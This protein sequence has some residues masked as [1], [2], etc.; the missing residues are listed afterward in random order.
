ML[1]CE[2]SAKRAMAV[3]RQGADGGGCSAQEVLGVG[4]T[5]AWGGGHEGRQRGSKRRRRLCQVW[6]DKQASVRWGGN[7]EWHSRHREER[8]RGAEEGGSRKEVPW[9]VEQEG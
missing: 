3:P 1:G 7:G 5:P 6:K 8:C 2:L 9:V 4:I